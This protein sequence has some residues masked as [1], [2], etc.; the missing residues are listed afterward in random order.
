VTHDQ[1]RKKV[2][3]DAVVAILPLYSLYYKD[4]GLGGGGDLESDAQRPRC[5]SSVLQLPLL[6]LLPTMT[7]SS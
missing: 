5:W 3:F 7:T 6:L 4:F 1:K 2:A